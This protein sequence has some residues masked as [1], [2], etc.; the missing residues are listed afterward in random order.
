MP[1]RKKCRRVCFVPDN[2]M[3]YPQEHSKEEVVLSV[4]EF[5]AIRLSDY[6][7]MDQD[8]SSGKMNISRGTFQRIIN[9]AKYKIADAMVNGKI[10][11]ISGGNYEEVC[12]K[13]TCKVP[14][15]KCRGEKF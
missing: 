3:F 15:R 5:E 1:R 11:K 8:E 7:R 10:I 13:E 6:E 2:Q 12:G 9:E 4:E 14:C